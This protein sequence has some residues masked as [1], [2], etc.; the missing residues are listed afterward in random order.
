MFGLFKRAASAPDPSEPTE[1][2][3]EAVFQAIAQLGLDLED[4]SF[5]HFKN[6]RTLARGTSMVAIG[7]GNTRRSPTGFFV[8][9]NGAAALRSGLMP[10]AVFEGAHALA[11][12]AE[13]RGVPLIGLLP[14][15]GQGAGDR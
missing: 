9:V 5:A 12:E 6:P 13:A 14:T 4:F 7:E 10:H 1:A 2:E 15:E 3:Y 11:A 8:E